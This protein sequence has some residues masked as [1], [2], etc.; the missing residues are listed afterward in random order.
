MQLGQE[1]RRGGYLVGVHV[2]L[3]ALPKERRPLAIASGKGAI[4]VA[5]LCLAC[6]SE[7]TSGTP[8]PPSTSTDA[9][10]TGTD[11][12][13]ECGAGTVGE[14]M[15]VGGGG[16]LVV[17][18][19]YFY[20][21]YFDSAAEDFQ[22]GKGNVA[23]GPTTALARATGYRE[24]PPLYPRYLGA[25]GGAVYFV[26][27]GG[28]GNDVPTNEALRTVPAESGEVKALISGYVGTTEVAQSALVVVRYDAERRSWLELVNPADDSVAPFCPGFD[29]P[30]Y[31]AMLAGSQAG[32]YWL[33]PEPPSN[34]ASL[35]NCDIREGVARTVATIEGYPYRFQQLV[36]DDAHAYWSD[37]NLQ[38]R[39]IWRI[40]LTGGA[41]ELLAAEEATSVLRLDPT[42]IY[43][44]RHHPCT[45][46]D[47]S[48]LADLCRIPK[49]GGPPEVLVANE[50]IAPYDLQ[51]DE[52]HVWWV[53]MGD[54]A[55]MADKSCVRRLT[56]P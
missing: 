6:G 50:R 26:V 43:Y 22:I 49:A 44:I 11:P 53:S 23:G 12:G 25:V 42:H 27:E 54:S 18:G 40:A 16:G 32:V 36:V 33:T 1:G 39:G 34:S 55:S 9:G 31:R 8:P 47:C 7:S 29:H 48:A 19:S 35:W 24:S 28:D 2:I 20:Y 52:R 51:L 38:T 41:P 21:F 15:A 3:G 5:L 45:P 46:R 56:K 14:V 4:G 13:A 10:D 17:D 30:G 37:S